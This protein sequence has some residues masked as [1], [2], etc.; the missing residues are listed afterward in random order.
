MLRRM[1]VRI[2]GENSSPPQ[3]GREGGEEK[4]SNRNLDG[5]TWIFLIVFLGP[6]PSTEPFVFRARK[7]SPLE[8]K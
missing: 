4:M 6:I 7:E 8:R 3:A 2:L 1:P 5:D